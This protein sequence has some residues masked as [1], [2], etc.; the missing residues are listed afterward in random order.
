MASLSV[1]DRLR[2]RRMRARELG[3]LAAAA[4]AAAIVGMALASVTARFGPWILL[5]VAVAVAASAAVLID[6]SW[7][8]V[9]LFLLFPVGLQ[10]VGPLQVVELA[11]LLV[12]ALVGAVSLG[13][14]RSWWV[15]R[16]VQ[17]SLG[18]VLLVGAAAMAG[19]VATELSR[20][21]LV[22]LAVGAGLM[23]TVSASVDSAAQLRRLVSVLVVVGAGI[24]VAAAA[25]IGP[26]T[27]AYGG[28]EVSG[29]AQGIFAQPNEL[30]AFTAAV[31]V[32]AVGLWV[33]SR[34][35]VSS[36]VAS[37]SIIALLA[38]LLSSLSR[39]AWIGAAAGL[40]AVVVMVARQPG[41]RGRL[42]ALGLPLV[43]LA[44]S[45]PLLL[46][47]HPLSQVI[48]SRIGSISDTGANPNDARPEIY[49][50]AVRLISG[51]PLLGTGPGTFSTTYAE[52]AGT[53]R[54]G[55]AEHAHNIVLTLSAE[56]GLLGLVAF[57]ALATAVLVSGWQAVRALQRRGTGR[58]AALCAGAIGAL[59]T[60]LGHGA[61]DYPL[62]NPTLFF[63]HWAMA[64][65]VLA[66][67]RVAR[68]HR[69]APAEAMT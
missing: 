66:Y 56:F 35:L 3:G 45:A 50:E 29:R 68:V 25:S 20:P 41:A 67:A 34:T 47:S 4:V 40:V 22:Q 52:T 11:A 7:A 51:N 60:V 16:S 39:G 23:V 43:L 54:S 8:V 19:S 6:P 21:A 15:P 63:L 58:E 9:G 53:G 38:A 61:I 27:S 46:S 13:G 31:V 12:I 59:V 14:S 48:V 17:V 33:G 36:V 49:D 5:V 32:L 24:S 57:A 2:S 65:L 62:R 28:G 18:A 30:G 44:F 42:V 69:A 55:N 26:V 64:G 37:V 10:R 1:P